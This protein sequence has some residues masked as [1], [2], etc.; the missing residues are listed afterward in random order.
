MSPLFSLAQLQLEREGRRAQIVS[1]DNSRELTVGSALRVSTY[2]Q[3]RRNSVK[4][5]QEKRMWGGVSLA[6]ARDGGGPAPSERLPSKGRGTAELTLVCPSTG[7]NG[8]HGSRARV[9][10]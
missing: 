4:L 5:E 1:G 10:E 3:A 2:R 7:R 6:A 8:C 9:G